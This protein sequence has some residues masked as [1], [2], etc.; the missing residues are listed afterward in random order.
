MS[1][2]WLITVFAGCLAAI[3]LVGTMFG[4]MVNASS[5]LRQCFT[6]GRWCL[7]LAG[8]L[9]MLGSLVG[10]LETSELFNGLLM[11]LFGSGAS[12]EPSKRTQCG[13]GDA[14]SR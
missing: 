13:S 7:C 12:L 11:V 10:I 3:G 5:V 6:T 1:A 8:L 2:H 4:A 9:L 14:V